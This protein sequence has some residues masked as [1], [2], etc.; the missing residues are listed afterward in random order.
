MSAPDPSLI[1]ASP[2]PLNPYTRFPFLIDPFPAD[3]L[4]S[5][6]AANLAAREEPV[7]PPDNPNRLEPR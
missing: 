3:T 4:F 1:V 7:D 5:T 2:P 6:S